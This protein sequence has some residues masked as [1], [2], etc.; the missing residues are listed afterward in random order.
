MTSH[1]RSPPFT[2][3]APQPAHTRAS[4]PLRARLLEDGLRLMGFSREDKAAFQSYL[5]VR[6]LPP[7]WLQ[8]AR[9]HQP[10]P[11]SLLRQGRHV[12]LRLANNLSHPRPGTRDI[13][14]DGC[15]VR[16]VLDSWVVVD[17]LTP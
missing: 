14:L 2:P 16:L 4:S 10:L 8:Q 1:D 9:F 13:Y 3:H 15:V 5:A 17:I 11:A 6:V 12:P 7:A